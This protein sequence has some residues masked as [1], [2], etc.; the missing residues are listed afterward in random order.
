SSSRPTFL[1]AFQRFVSIPALLPCGA[2][3]PNGRDFTPDQ[4]QLELRGRLSS[5]PQNM[6]D[7]FGRRISLAELEPRPHGYD[8]RAR[9]VRRGARTVRRVTLVVLTACLVAALAGHPGAA[10]AEPP[11]AL[12]HL[13]GCFEVSYRFVE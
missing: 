12:R 4:S 1:S 11:G 2:P 3:C 5:Y 13:A 9:T 8:V 10:A 7:P 6:A